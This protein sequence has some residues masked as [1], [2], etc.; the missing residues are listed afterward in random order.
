MVKRSWAGWKRGIA[1]VWGWNCDC[2]NP[3]GEI[4]VH[5]PRLYIVTWYVYVLL[6]GIAEVARHWNI[7]LRSINRLVSVLCEIREAAWNCRGIEGEIAR[8]CFKE[9]EY[10]ST[11]MYTI[12]FFRIFRTFVYARIEEVCWNCAKVN[13]RWNCIQSSLHLTYTTCLRLNF[14]RVRTGTTLRVDNM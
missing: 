12:L 3:M 6:A 4:D 5:G 14:F 1:R 10:R 7:Q 11:F 8:S 2:E 13:E 9:S